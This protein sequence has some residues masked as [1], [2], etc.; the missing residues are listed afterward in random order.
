MSARL[1]E[2]DASRTA[3]AVI[4]SDDLLGSES[5]NSVAG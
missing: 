4:G 1:S 5:Y 3:H 2:G